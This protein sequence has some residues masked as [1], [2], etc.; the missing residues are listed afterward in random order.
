MWGSI[1]YEANGNCKAKNNRYTK[2]KGTK[3]YHYRKSS[4]HRGREQKKKGMKELQ[5]NHK[6]MNKMTVVS[7][8][9]LILL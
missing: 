7:P 3:A 9:L 5:K 6:T 1:K 8:Y 2:E 4:N